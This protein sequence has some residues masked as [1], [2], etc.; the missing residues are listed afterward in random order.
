MDKRSAGGSIDLHGDEVIEQFSGKMCLLKTW[1][2]WSLQT[3]SCTQSLNEFYG[4]MSPDHAWFTHRHVYRQLQLFV[5]VTW[6]SIDSDTVD[7]L[8]LI[9]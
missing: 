7:K 4:T 8:L 1:G 9:L 3:E 2:N 6:L 5:N